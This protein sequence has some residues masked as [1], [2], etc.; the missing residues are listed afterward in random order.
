MGAGSFHSRRN[1][2]GDD[3][4]T[5]PTLRA[6][7]GRDSCGNPHPFPSSRCLQLPALCLPSPLSTGQL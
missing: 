1:G 4:S 5:I 7:Q 6:G 2:N 3:A